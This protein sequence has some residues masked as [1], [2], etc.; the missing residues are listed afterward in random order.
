MTSSTI[1][2]LCV[3][4]QDGAKQWTVAICWGGV[5]EYLGSFDDYSKAVEF[6]AAEHKRRTEEGE[7]LAVHYSSHC[8]C[9]CFETI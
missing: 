3:L 8:P 5:R 7:E 1:G 2:D 6:A 4:N 9:P